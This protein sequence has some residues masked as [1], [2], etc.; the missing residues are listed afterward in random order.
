[1]F[2]ELQA[3]GGLKHAKAVKTNSNNINVYNNSNSDSS[4]DSSSNEKFK[5]IDN[6]DIPNLG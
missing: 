3:A 2:N 5:R 4:S 1:M 6:K